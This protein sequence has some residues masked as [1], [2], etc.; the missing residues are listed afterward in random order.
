MPAAR[1]ALALA[2]GAVAALGFLP[3]LLGVLPQVAA[4]AT[5]AGVAALWRLC[6]AA[7]RHAAWT[8]L[9][10][11]FG[12][13]TLG[14]HW[15][16]QSFT[17]QAKMP[18][19]LG[20]VAVVALA[21]VLAAFPA[22]ASWLAFRLP[23]KPQG[24]V[25]AFAAA[26]M[27]GEWARGWVLTGFPWNPL[28]AVALLEQA[29]G[30]AAAA[31]WVGAL[32]VSGLVA[33]MA[34]LAGWLAWRGGWGRLAAPAVAAG[35]PLVLAVLLD[36]APPALATTA[37]GP[38]LLIVQPDIGQD[39][40]WA[41]ARAEVH[42]ARLMALSREG[43]P[44]RPGVARLILWPEVALPKAELE[45]DAALRAYLATLLRPGDLLLSGG[46]AVARDAAG[47]ATA[48]AN[49]LFVLDHAGAIVARYDKHHLVPGGEYV[50]LKPLADALGLSRLAPG[51]L[52]FTPGPG[53][54]TVALPGL[55]AA[56]PMI[57][58]EMIFP[59]RIVERG[60]R[61]PA[62]M[63]NPSNDA[64]F[65]AAG[66]PQHLALAR[67]RAIEEG[68]PMARATPT[69]ISALVGPDGTL[70]AAL[71]QRAMG[72]VARPLPP[73]R[74]PTP[75]AR[76]SHATSLALALLLGALAR[77]AREWNQT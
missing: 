44:A 58:F 63:F 19:E 40:K 52:G 38:D 50:P 48:A 73:P 59:G 17:Y 69:G 8:G 10:W 20:W 7:P 45:R 56:G 25:P 62:W 9:A 41:A 35:T 30:A 18:A 28:A 64:W 77:V 76:F 16:A 57:C 4:V 66:P 36:R 6:Q 27:L 65:G 12:H 15:L 61:R 2:A 47:R 46:L 31:A 68:L 1:L 51:S 22:L 60:P 3:A 49:S 39:E 14:C 70:L 5:L 42:L 11:G 37:P 53:P 29:P 32:G 26:W 13:F 74:P 23:L 24:R 21:A 43:P 54:R 67:L 75:F 34:A 72:V 71:G 55:P 33:L